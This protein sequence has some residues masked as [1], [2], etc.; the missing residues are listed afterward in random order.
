MKP[1][2]DG[3]VAVA[4]FNRFFLERDF[5]LPLLRFGIQEDWRVRCV[6]AQKDLGVTRHGEWTWTVKAV[7]PHGTM[8]LRFYPPKTWEASV[9]SAA[10][11]PDCPKVAPAV[12]D[13][14][15]GAVPTNV[16]KRSGVKQASCKFHARMEP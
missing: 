12:A 6:W 2:S 7:P 5:R 3:S 15:F 4:C 1:L 13:I 10:D 9:A 8:I 16:I 14:D 11:C